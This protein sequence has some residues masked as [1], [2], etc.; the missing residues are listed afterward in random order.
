MELCPTA[1]TRRGSADNIAGETYGKPVF[2][3]DGVSHLAAAQVFYTPS[4]RTNWHS[5]P[6]GQL[7]ICTDGIGLLVSR[8]GTTIRTRAGDAVWTPAGEEHWH[9][10]TNDHSVCHYQIIDK[11]QHPDATIWA[12]PVTEEQY[13]AANVVA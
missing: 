7:L 9:G 6:N 1:A 11:G 3:G 8:D 5:H 12:E 4:S 13:A 10:A 2:V